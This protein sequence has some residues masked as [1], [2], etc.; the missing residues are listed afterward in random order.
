MIEG[1]ILG[2]ENRAAE[3][4]HSEEHRE[5]KKIFKIQILRD[6]WDNITR[7]NVCINRVSGREKKEKSTKKI[8]EI[9]AEI[10]PKLVKY[11]NL[12]I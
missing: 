5:N 8:E 3:L 6:M 1:T 7:S 2:F 12:Q 4:M 10:Y 11:I 9:K